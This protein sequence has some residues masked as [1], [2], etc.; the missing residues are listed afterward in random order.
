M[1]SD[2]SRV[3]I[4][5]IVRPPRHSFSEASGQS[6]RRPSG[7]LAAVRR[8]PHTCRHQLL[9]GV[10]TIISHSL[11]ACVR[12]RG[13]LPAAASGPATA[14]AAVSPTVAARRCGSAIGSLPRSF[15]AADW[16]GHVHGARWL[17][18]DRGRPCDCGVILLE[19]DRV[20]VEVP[21]AHIAANAKNASEGA[22]RVIVIVAE[23]RGHEG[24]P[25]ATDGTEF[26][27]R[28]ERRCDVAGRTAEL[29]PTEACGESVFGAQIWDRRRSRWAAQVGSRRQK[30]PGPFT[31]TAR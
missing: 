15:P 29:V 10:S 28:P 16:A 31:P 4:A 17:Q 3:A 21:E 12:A 6:E 2:T 25:L 26:L 9:R 30:R 19:G 7:S 27:L 1:S 24:I 23:R 18:L 8:R 22:R 14:G 5:S 11:R 20:I 13:L